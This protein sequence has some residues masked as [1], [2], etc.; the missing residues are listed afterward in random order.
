MAAAPTLNPV[1]VPPFAKKVMKLAAHAA[2]SGHHHRHPKDH[3][4]P[5]DR[6]ADG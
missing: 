1:D 6:S 3:D 2:E 5:R 4:Q